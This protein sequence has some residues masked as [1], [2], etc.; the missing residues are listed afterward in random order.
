MEMVVHQSPR[1]VSPKKL[2]LSPERKLHLEQQTSAKTQV[3]LDEESTTDDFYHIN[4][5]SPP[6]SPPRGLKAR[7]ARDREMVRQRAIEI[8]A[9]QLA[10]ED[11]DSD[12]DKESKK[13]D[14]Q[15]FLVL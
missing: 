9:T 8:A 10:E 14:E 15:L 6:N 5:V 4:V 11:T 13:I 7:M 12:F 1:S 3:P 2:V